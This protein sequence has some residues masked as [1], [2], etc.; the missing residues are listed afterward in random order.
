MNRFLKS[1]IVECSAYILRIITAI[2]I[3]VIAIS[4]VFLISKDMWKTFEAYVKDSE[5]QHAVATEADEVIS[6]D[7]ITI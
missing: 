3:S 6:T 1:G 4:V 5:A 2:I 7:S